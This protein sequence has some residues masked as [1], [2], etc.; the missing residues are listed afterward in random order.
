MLR[1]LLALLLALVPS[2]LGSQA[3]AAPERIQV[4][5]GVVL[6]RTAPY[7]DVGLDGNAVVILSNDGVL[8]FDANGT[9]A[10]AESVLAGIR[11]MTDQPVRWL[12]LS[13]W[14]WDHWYGA[15]A[16]RRA[17]P[18]IRIVAHEATRR[19]MMDPA[20]AFNQPGL[21][22]QLPEH[23]TA[24]EQ[25]VAATAATDTVPGRLARLQ[26]HLA[27][28]RFFLAQKRGA[29]HT[30]PDTTFT[31]SLVIRLGTREVRVLHVDRAV[32]P[33]DSWL[34]LPR[35]R[36][37][38]TGDLL[39]N[40]IPFALGCY[41][42][43]WIRALEDIRA[44]N[45]AAIVPGH[46]MPLRDQVLLDQ[47]LTLLQQLQ[48]LGTAAK[49]RGLGVEQA[50][51]EAM[52]SLRPRMIELTHDDARLN[53]QFEIYLVDWFLHRVYDQLEGRL[54]DEIAPIPQHGP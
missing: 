19:L 40:P 49:A 26:R 27:D 44:R 42:G 53:Q 34:W 10:A 37:A 28:D 31:D 11:R 50:R 54:T 25:A 30:F 35:E 46:G 29:R 32:T 41:P 6:F 24:V 22:D 23:I 9:P 12:V 18:G 52:D 39:V 7:S 8:V 13:H 38:V 4:A 17:F 45:A 15:E 1:R 47:H 20:L 3:P 5:D 21:D 14:H 33:G 51:A 2:S 48:R 36:I 16:Y 43:G